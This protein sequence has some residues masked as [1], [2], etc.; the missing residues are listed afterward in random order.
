MDNSLNLNRDTLQKFTN[1]EEEAPSIK[2]ECG[3]NICNNLSAPD[4]SES[5]EASSL[6]S[7][8]TK[9]IH[10]T[11]KSAPHFSKQSR[12]ARPKIAVQIPE[13]EGIFELFK[14]TAQQMQPVV[15]PAEGYKTPYAYLSDTDF[16]A[17]KEEENKIIHSHISMKSYHLAHQLST[18]RWTTG[19]G[20]RIGCMRDYPYEL[21]FSVMEEVQ[22]SPRTAFPTPPKA[23]RCYTPTIFSREANDQCKRPDFELTVFS[24]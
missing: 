19:A 15:T 6:K 8:D 2:K 20:P 24:V 10:S 3:T 7:L 13:K 4:L 21:Q 11:N 23:A 5:S 16:S 1:Y 14:K 22:L 17:S 18:C 12:G 9:K